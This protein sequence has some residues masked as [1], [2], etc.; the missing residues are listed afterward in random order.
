MGNKK[1]ITIEHT[2]DKSTIR[3]TSFD[4]KI[5]FS[6]TSTHVLVYFNDLLSPKYDF[7]AELLILHRNQPQATVF[8]LEIPSGSNFATLVFTTGMTDYKIES[9]IAVAV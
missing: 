3:V 2:I 9:I 5:D 6:K 8:D 7:Y 4:G 1:V